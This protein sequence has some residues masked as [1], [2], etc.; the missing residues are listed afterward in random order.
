MEG[1]RKIC[2]T[3]SSQRIAATPQN[4]RRPGKDA[5]LRD[6]ERAVRR[7]TAGDDAD[8]DPRMG[9]SEVIVIERPERDW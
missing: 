4:L 9:R 2:A 1:P 8:T 3:P 6:V 7:I 5:E